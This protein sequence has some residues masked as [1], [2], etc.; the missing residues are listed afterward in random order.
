[1]VE[2]TPLEG[3]LV[4]RIR[5]RYSTEEE[6]LEYA[7]DIIKNKLK[8]YRVPTY[9]EVQLL[10]K[11]MLIKILYYCPESD[12]YY[13]DHETIKEMLEKWTR[14]QVLQQVKQLI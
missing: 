1:M 11:S 14:K 6:C 10:G 2:V 8:V 9:E 5:D 13:D 3:K 4:R 7:R 12:F